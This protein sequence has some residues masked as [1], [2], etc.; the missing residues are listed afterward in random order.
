MSRKKNKLLY[1]WGVVDV[2]YNV[3]KSEILNGK[4][5][6]VWICPYYLKWREILRRCLCP[7]N[8]TKTPNLQR[9]HSIRRMEVFI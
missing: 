3:T 6:R 8:P 1:G 7:K 9:L 4:R 2:D 5:K